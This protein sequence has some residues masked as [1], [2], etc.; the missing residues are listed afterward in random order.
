MWEEKRKW[1]GNK[2]SRPALLN[3]SQRQSEV[4]VGDD[5]RGSAL[6]VGRTAPR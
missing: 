1:V 4:G 3:K 5:F 2:K 6:V